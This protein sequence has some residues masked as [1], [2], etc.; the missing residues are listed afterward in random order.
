MSAVNSAAR[1]L[2]SSNESSK[3]TRC[4]RSPD[5]AFCSAALAKRS[6]S[7]S[8][9]TPLAWALTTPR[10]APT[11]TSSVSVWNGSLK[12]PRRLRMQDSVCATPAA[13]GSTTRNSSPEMRPTSARPQRGVD[14]PEAVHTEQQQ[15]HLTRLGPAAGRHQPLAVGQAGDGIQ[16]GHVVQ[17]AQLGP[18][19]L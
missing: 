5:L 11:S 7:R 6:R 10:L 17:L 19:A 3:L 2:R 12:Q 13:P 8:N 9:A 14:G 16:Q 1:R 4:P 15:R 18:D